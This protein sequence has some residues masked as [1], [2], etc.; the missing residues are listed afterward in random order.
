MIFLS[1]FD[2]E[3]SNTSQGLLDLTI[4]LVL[5]SAMWMLLTSVNLRHSFFVPNV[6]VM[7][8]ASIPCKPEHSNATLYY[9]GFHEFQVHNKNQ[10]LHKN[11]RRNKPGIRLKEV[12]QP[13]AEYRPPPGFT[14]VPA[15][16]RGQPS[17]VE[18]DASR[19]SR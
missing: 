13:P 17:Q 9:I 19:L 16:V 4:T 1:G 12:M 10:E 18:R 3:Q 2:S 6:P 11:L 14:L 5:C 7:S 15:I 8:S